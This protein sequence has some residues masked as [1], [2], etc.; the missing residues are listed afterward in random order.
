MSAA[1]GRPPLVLVP[2][3]C[4]GGWAWDEVA[5]RL[6]A[7]GRDVFPVTLTGLGERVHLAT[8]E[9]DLD[10][11]ITDVVNLLDYE[12]L[13]D[14]VLVG[15]SYAGIVVTGVADRRPE[16]LNAVVYFDSSPLPDGMAIAD[17]APPEMRER[18]QREAESH[19]GGWRWPV[20]DRQTIESGAFGSAAGLDETHLRLLTER[21]TPQPYATFT[22][23]LRLT[24]ERPP[25]VRRAVVFC[26]AG[27]IDIALLQHM[28]EQGDRRAQM[29]AAADWELHEIATGHWAMFS[30]PELTAELLGEIADGAEPGQQAEPT[31]LSK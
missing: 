2:G 16:R 20:P 3:A 31:H 30:E 29:F 19:G 5:H 23:P 13:H 27:G 25:G 28:L 24:H 12:D 22:T 6:R 14:A 15:H 11:H 21:G 9:V 18:Q 4:L 26:T 8:P 7:R 10:T 1:G 17:A